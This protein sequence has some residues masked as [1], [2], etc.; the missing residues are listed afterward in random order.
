MTVADSTKVENF[1]CRNF[2]QARKFTQ[3]HRIHRGLILILNFATTSSPGQSRR[4]DINTEKLELPSISQVQTRGPADIPFYNSHY[5]QRPLLSS[6]RLPHLNLPQSYAASS[7]YG[8]APPR[9]VLPEPQISG[10]Q[11]GPSAYPSA[12]QGIGLKTPSP[13]PTGQNL[14]PPHPHGIPD[15]SSEH[16]DYPTH[17]QS[18]QPYDPIVERF[19]DAMNQQQYMDSHQSYSSAGQSYASQP[20]TA[21]NMSHY[22]QYQQ[23]P[24]V[25]QPGPGTYAPS[26]T[27]YNQQYN[28]QNGVASPQSAGHSV[29]SSMGSQM[30]SAM[31]PL[32]GKL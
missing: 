15:D 9:S 30:N 8:P 1:N 17:S 32:P 19:K 24:P 27:S 3:K 14:T 26:P 2:R 18:I 5:Y 6:D 21:G 20:T 4:V 29:P 7:S 28:Y 25:L 23:Q 31:L 13:S 11:Y 10:S 12:Q 22:P 16:P